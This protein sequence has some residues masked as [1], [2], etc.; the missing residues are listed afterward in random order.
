MKGPDV[1]QLN[2][3]LV[4]LGYDD[5][6]G[7]EADSSYFSQATVDAVERLQDAVNAKET[8][9]LDLGQAVFLPTDELRITKRT[10]IYGA[11]APA[12]QSLFKA[13][14]T[15]S[16][17]SISM[18]ASLATHVRR[19]DKVTAELP[20]GKEAKGEVTSVGRVATTTSDGSTIPVQVGLSG[21]KGAGGLDAATVKVVITANS[22]KN[23]LAVP[24]TALLAMAGGGYSVEVIGAANARS[25]TPVKIGVFDG[26]AGMVEITSGLTE[27]QRIVVPSS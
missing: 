1:K 4:K 22:K 3:A 20:T 10:G 5:D 18:D 25:L 8:G 17:V 21:A 23:V 26:A 13:S 24:V 15:M 6:Y 16:V 7:P 19:G 14:S 9:E 12:G 27:G 2:A 11:N